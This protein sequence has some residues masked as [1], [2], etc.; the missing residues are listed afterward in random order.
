[1]LISIGFEARNICLL[2]F[3]LNFQIFIEMYY[4]VDAKLTSTLL[5]HLAVLG[6]G[7]WAALK[8]LI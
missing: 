2:H 5:L 4:V 3:I 6:F 1:M 7:A 8:K